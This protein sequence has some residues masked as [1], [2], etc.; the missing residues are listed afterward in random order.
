MTR[1]ALDG[2]EKYLGKGDQLTKLCANNLNILLE[3]Q[4]KINEKAALEV[5][6]PESGLDWSSVA[7]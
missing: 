4:G 7:D 6:Y 2:H 5:V 1:L 3:D